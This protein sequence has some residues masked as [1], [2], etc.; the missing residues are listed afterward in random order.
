MVADI[1]A[2]AMRSLPALGLAGLLTLGLALYVASAFITLRPP[3]SVYRALLS[4]PGFLVWK[5]WV[6]LVLRKRRN[7]ASDWV[8]TARAQRT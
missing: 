4:A 8:R 5:L 7:R 2:V 1:A 3:W 6:T